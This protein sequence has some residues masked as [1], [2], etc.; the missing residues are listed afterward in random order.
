VLEAALARHLRVVRMG[1][2]GADQPLRIAPLAQD[3][4][5]AERVV[6]QIRVP[7]VVEVMQERCNA[8]RLLVLAELTGVAADG[9]LDGEGMLCG[10]SRSA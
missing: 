10:G 7:I 9:R 5:A 1:Q 8:P 3:L 2:H 4:G 6:R